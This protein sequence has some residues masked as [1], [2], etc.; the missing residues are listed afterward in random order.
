MRA[1]R[2]AE[3]AK[4]NEAPGPPVAARNPR[5]RHWHETA[6]VALVMIIA[7]VGGYYGFYVTSRVDQLSDSYSRNLASAATIVQQAIEDAWLN[8]CNTE[9]ARERLSMIAGIKVSSWTRAEEA[10]RDDKPAAEQDVDQCAGITSL[11]T[12]AGWHQGAAVLQFSTAGNVARM[13]LLPLLESAL[14]VSEFDSVLL[15]R[16]TGEVLISR[17]GKEL[18]IMMLPMDEAAAGE[19]ADGEA[20]RGKASLHDRYTTVTD[21]EAAGTAYKLFAQPVRVPIDLRWKGRR[22]G[23]GTATANGDAGEVE[24]AWMLVGLKRNNTFLTEAMAISPTVLLV[25]FGAGIV[26]LLALPYLKLRYLGRREA[27]HTHDVLVL[28]SAL[29]IGTTIAT[30]A[31]LEVY[32]RL[33]LDD[34]MDDRLNAFAGEISD[35]FHAE[36]ACLGDQLQRLTSL[37]RVDGRPIRVTLLGQEENVQ[38]LTYP[39]LELAFWLDESGG[40][41]KKW[42]VSDSATTLISVGTRRYFTAARNMQFE[43]VST[44]GC[45]LAEGTGEADPGDHTADGYFLESIRSRTTGEVSAVLSQRLADDAGK[46]SSSKP[47]PAADAEPLIAAAASAPLLS[48]TGPTLRPG[49]SF[50]VIDMQGQAL[51][52]SN[53]TRNLRENFFDELDEPLPIRAAV[54][55][56]TTVPIGTDA[57]AA[58]QEY[59][60]EPMSVEYRARTHRANLTRL[61][62]ADWTLVS[63][64]DVSAYGVARAEVLTFA[65]A[66][67]LVYTVL[68]LILFAVL[69]A[70][71]VGF[72]GSNGSFFHWMWPAP[73]KRDVYLGI[74]LFVI[75][76]SLLWLLVQFLTS[77]LV[78]VMLSGLLGLVTLFV[79]FE[80]FRAAA[81]KS[82]HRA[83]LARVG[84]W[85]V[86]LAA[87]RRAAPER[88]RAARAAE[89]ASAGGLPDSVF[90]L[91][92]LIVVGIIIVLSVLPPIAFYR[93]ANNE[94]MELFTMSDQLRWADRIHVRSELLS[95][96]YRST[97]LDSSAHAAISGHLFPESGDLGES[98]DMHTAG[99]KACVGRKCATGWQDGGGN[100][101]TASVNPAADRGGRPRDGDR[102]L[103]QPIAAILGRDLPGLLRESWE[104]RS[105]A[106]DENRRWHRNGNEIVFSDLTFRSRPGLGEQGGRARLPE[107]LQE[108]GLY[109][110][111]PWLGLALPGADPSAWTILM[112]L[113]AAG[114]LALWVMIRRL[115]RLIFLTDLRQPKFLP[116]R[117]WEELDGYQRALVLR[118]RLEGEPAADGQAVFQVD[119]TRSASD[120]TDIQELEEHPAAASSALVIVRRFHDGLWDPDIAEQ[121]LSLLERL[122]ALDCRVVV[123]SDVNPM[124]YFTM[125]AG[126]HFRGSTPV[127][128]D[129]GRWAAVLAEFH[130]FRDLPL[131]ELETE[132]L[133]RRLITIRSPDPGGAGDAERT[134]LLRLAA[135]CWPNEHLKRIAFC[136]ARRK[137][138]TELM[139]G[140][141]DEALVRQVLDLAEAHY[142]VLWAI[143]GKDERMVLYRLARNGFASWRGSELVRRLLH[144]GLVR[145]DPG[146]V[147]MNESFREFVLTAELPE[148]FELW[149]REEG[150]SP[151]ARLRTPIIVAVL[152]VFLFLFATQPQLFSQG[153]AFTTAV[154]AIVPAFIKLISLVAGTRSEGTS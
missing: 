66:L 58:P 52:H 148:V 96:R 11:E 93:A 56:R 62:G 44:I 36:V 84:G 4:G 8:V 2:S 51:L 61:D 128:P 143:S 31:V 154:A 47:G 69:H 5:R 151:W 142:R 144:R 20:S 114:V 100:D 107:K 63:L 102:V 87:G 119:S 89:G 126:D 35:A 19:Q 94:I 12:V 139:P 116:V 60:S 112:L 109:L 13:P 105:V 75:T 127:R 99:W 153:L 18:N 29:L 97:D 42:T 16:T 115:A 37:Q 23:S 24:D 1:S 138:L 82:R 122:L 88:L 79:C 111:S 67:S 17:G 101:G 113:I 81:M 25:A 149:T 121:K 134:V 43:N 72:G 27:L 30:F 145:L 92:A 123:H 90:R 110:A 146:P 53:A 22:L 41:I 86:S 135:E 71:R 55:S 48:V 91:H 54:W 6:A 150:A 129:L 137:D 57:S 140:G 7:V 49:F 118:S 83:L 152:G 64:Y 45:P 85:A 141:D 136:L 103:R 26:V 132:E 28:T 131:D 98:W 147:I 10:Q 21:F 124:H 73:G 65:L 106:R 77:T 38:L 39:F 117:K 15:S 40:Q 33:N 78:S 14:P 3:E 95:R 76:V 80:T 46:V 108:A 133:Y 50:V 125:I 120:L 74:L 70:V 68:L 32:A 34:T 130:R 59:L 104:I 9:F